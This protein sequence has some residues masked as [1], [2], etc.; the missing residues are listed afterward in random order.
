MRVLHVYDDRFNEHLNPPGHPERPERLDA[1]VRGV[2]SARGIE[3]IEMLP[4]PADPDLIHLVHTPNYVRFIEEVSKTGGGRLDPDTSASSGSWE[5]AIRAAGAGPL[6]VQALQ[7]GIA[8]SAFLSLRPPGHHAEADRAMGFC[9]FNNV[10]ITAAWLAE[11]GNRVAIFDWDVHHGNGT[12]HSLYRHPDI[13]FVSMHEYPLYPGTGWLDECGTGKGEGL[14][15]NIPVAARTG[16]DLYSAATENVIVPILTEFEPDWLLVSAGYDAHVRD[17]LAS[18]RLQGGD[19]AVITSM[20]GSVVPPNRTIFFLEGGYDL[21]AL[22]TSTR[23][24]LEAIG[25]ADS[26]GSEDAARTEREA[27]ERLAAAETTQKRYWKL[28]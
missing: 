23:A 26:D 8:D 22:E 17:P 25:T 5:A 7:D 6:A 4:E 15:I 16:G 28:T 1:V 24:T 11:A 21:H 12:Q 20:L 3:L 14:T 27:W 9:L 18:V 10:A 13:L 19:Y 2:R